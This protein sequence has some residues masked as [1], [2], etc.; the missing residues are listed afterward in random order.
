MSC[1]TTEFGSLENLISIF[2]PPFAYNGSFKFSIGSAKVL[3]PPVYLLN[4]LN[5]PFI[6]DTFSL[7]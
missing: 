1:I 5:S 2:S 6:V 3:F 7:L 4:Q